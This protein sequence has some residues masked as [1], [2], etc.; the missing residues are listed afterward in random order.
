MEID[1]VMKGIQE[2]NK[3]LNKSKTGRVV[4]NEEYIWCKADYS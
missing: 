3:G 1:T 2:E 4:A